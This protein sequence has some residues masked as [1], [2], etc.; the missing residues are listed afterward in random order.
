MKLLH[1]EG[2]KHLYGGPYQVLQLLRQAKGRGE[3]LLAC[4]KG[5][6]IAQ[7]A[8]KEGI[9]VIEIALQ[10]EGSVGAFFA[11]RSIIRSERPDL[12]QVHSRRGADLWG[13][14]AARSTKTPFIITRRVDNP[15]PRSLAK[16][17]YGKAVRVV[18]I[19]Q[20]ITEVLREEGVSGEK[21][22]CIRSGVDTR[23][24]APKEGRE[25]LQN[26]FGISPDE[27]VIAMAAQFIARK[28]HATLLEAVPAVLKQHPRAR[29][30]LLG[31]G[32]L[33]ETIQEKAQEFGDRVLLPGFRGDMD[34]I[35][36]EC[37]LLAHP[38][39]ME[40]L[41]VIVLQA[42]ACGLPVVGG[43]AG[44]IPEVI[45][46]GKSGYLIEP[47]DAPALATRISALLADEALRK[48]MGQ[49]AREFA[50]RELSI[51]AM[52]EGNLALYEEI[53]S[54]SK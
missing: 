10:G 51:E 9:K 49:C 32:P 54:E 12:V 45:L 8:R 29:F 52:A 39:H 41:G 36:P 11:L 31:K 4:P 6:A 26:A 27:P 30:L 48:T 38:A 44:G 43:R 16:L 53:L 18:G 28:G 14:L 22:R 35:L 40:G 17:R 37:T 7:A 21:L 2:G 24:Y 25:Y 46:E 23:A 19:S 20:K 15:E 3:H 1:I 42:A 50:V 47:G 5:S 13:V 34:K 33:W